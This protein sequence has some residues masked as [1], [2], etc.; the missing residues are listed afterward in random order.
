M[1]RIVL[2]LPFED[3]VAENVQIPET[4]PAASSLD[5]PGT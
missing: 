2:S 3:T 4:K 5:P 1:P